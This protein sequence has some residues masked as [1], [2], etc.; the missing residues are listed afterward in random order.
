MQ[1][2]TVAMDIH[3]AACQEGSSSPK[4]LTYYF[5]NPKYLPK[6]FTVDFNKIIP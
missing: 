1:M 4:C 5:C 3:N 2:P 6:I